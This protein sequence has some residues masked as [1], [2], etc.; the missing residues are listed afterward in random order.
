M[1]RRVLH[2]KWGEWPATSIYIP[3]DASRRFLLLELQPLRMA[4]FPNGE[5][6]GG[7]LIRSIC[8]WPRRIQ[9]IME[10]KKKV[11]SEMYRKLFGAGI[12]VEGAVHGDDGE[13]Q[14][15]RWG[16]FIQECDKSYIK[17]AHGSLYF[18]AAF[19]LSFACTPVS[20]RNSH[21]S[22]NRKYRAAA[23]LRD[24]IDSI[25]LADE[26]ARIVA[27]PL[28]SFALA[29]QPKTFKVLG[30]K[31]A[32]QQLPGGQQALEWWNAILAQD[33]DIPLQLL[34]NPVTWTAA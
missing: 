23:I 12:P 27:I 19:L 24:L 18:V 22:M 33:I 8:H 20:G 17:T 2:E 32:L 4:L 25:V 1:A 10:D 11:F 29:L 28:E 31:D 30:A 15:A 16:P 3:E 21:K 14:A 5:P 26:G 13:R 7:C 9:K 34:S 6:F